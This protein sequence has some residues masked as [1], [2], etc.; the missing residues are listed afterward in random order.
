[1]ELPIKR[2]KDFSFS[3]LE[4]YNKYIFL[5]INQEG[6]NS[7]MTNIY[8]SD[9]TGRNFS[10]NLMNVVKNNEGDI[11]FERVLSNPG[12]FIANI[13]DKQELDRIK[14]NHK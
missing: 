11:E 10:L 5:G 13:Y 6:H 2:N 12:T 9:I 14:T 8:S 4:S 7:K 3:V 1:M